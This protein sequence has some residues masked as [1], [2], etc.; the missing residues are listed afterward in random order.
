[1]DKQKDKI[2]KLLELSLSDNEHEASIA[3]R[4]AMSLMNKHNITKAD[5]YGQKMANKVIQTP[6]FRIP[7]WYISLYNLM[8]HVSG[9]FCVYQ[10]GDSY[11]QEYAEIQIT[12]RERDVD[13]A[14]YLI[15][16][17][18]R[19]I[20]K[21]AKEYRKQLA[22]KGIRNQIAQRVK[23]YRKGFINKIYLKIKSSQEQFFHSNGASGNQDTALVYL[24]IETRVS[25]AKSYYINELGYHC[26]TASSNTRYLRDSMHDG[27]KEADQL[28]IHSAVNQQETI[29]KLSY[30]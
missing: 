12:G 17:L 25:E 26:Y 20:E 8:S 28:E 27:A 23:A 16:F 29:K 3:L 14:N 1:M 6:Y 11:D 18:S 21:H 30:V 2:K 24:D 5:V 19:E 9:Y 7:E 10:N 4:Q 22:A 13:N 15:V